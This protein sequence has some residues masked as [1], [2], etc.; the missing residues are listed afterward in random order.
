TQP[1]RV[2]LYDHEE[3]LRFKRS[4]A[5][6]P[7]HLRPIV[8]GSFYLRGKDELLLDLRSCERA[9]LAIEFFDKYIPRS[10]ARV[11]AAE[12][13]NKLF[14]A[15]GN[16]QLTPDSIFDQQQRTSSEI[17]RIP[18]HYYEDSIDG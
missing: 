1:R 10:A 8:L 13:V 15:T 4:Y 6:F 11:T 12:V 5:E 14:P 3:G 16:R 2:W 9:L 7:E 18:V 17:E